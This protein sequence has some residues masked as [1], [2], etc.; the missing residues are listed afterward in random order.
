MEYRGKL[1]PAV[2]RN[3]FP[4]VGCYEHKHGRAIVSA[5]KDEDETTH[6][7]TIAVRW[8]VVFKV[9]ASNKIFKAC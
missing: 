7:L 6:G 9:L 3:E 8:T 2:V 1:Y 5:H 4:E